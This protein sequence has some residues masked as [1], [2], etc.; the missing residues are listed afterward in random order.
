M[1]N[2]MA[3]SA[4]SENKTKEVLAN[5]PSKER[6]LKEESKEK[7]EAWRKMAADEITRRV[8]YTGEGGVPLEKN[9]MGWIANNN[10]LWKDDSKGNVWSDFGRTVTGRLSSFL[11]NASF[12]PNAKTIGGMFSGIPAHNNIYKLGEKLVSCNIRLE[13]LEEEATEK[14]FANKE[15]YEKA[16]NEGTTN[17]LTEQEYA[18]FNKNQ[19]KWYVYKLLGYVER[20]NKATDKDED[21]IAK[22]VLAD[23]NKIFIQPKNADSIKM[24]VRKY[25]IANKKELLARLQNGKRGS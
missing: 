20:L 10:D 24:E 8:H 18:E 5:I 7:I 21:V 25:A 2:D 17:G 13:Q 1:S 12:S 23:F 11:G 22:E 9:N 19:G 16:M 6:I 14:N 3:L 15:A 4:I